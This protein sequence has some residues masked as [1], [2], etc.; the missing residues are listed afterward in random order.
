MKMEDGLNL[1]W[2]NRMKTSKKMEDDLKKQVNKH[3]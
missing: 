2:E 1:V 3:D